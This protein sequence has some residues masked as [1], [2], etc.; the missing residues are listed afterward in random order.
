[1]RLNVVPH[2]AREHAA[3]AR[4]ELARLAAAAAAGE[5]AAAAARLREDAARLGAPGLQR[6]G[7]LGAPPAPARAARRGAILHRRAA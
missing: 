2:W 7:P 4:E 3:A 5:R 6:G 1:V